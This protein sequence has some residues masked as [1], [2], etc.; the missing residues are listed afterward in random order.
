MTCH[1]TGMYSVGYYFS[2]LNVHSVLF[3]LFISIIFPY[4][5]TTPSTVHI[6]HIFIVTQSRFIQILQHLQTMP[7]NQWRWAPLFIFERP[8][9][10]AL[11]NAL[12][13]H[14]YNFDLHIANSAQSLSQASFGSEFKSSSDLEELLC[15]HLFWTCLKDLLDNGTTF[16]LIP[17]DESTRKEN[18]DYYQ[19]RGNHQFTTK[20]KEK[21]DVIITEDTECG[22]YSM[23]N[24]FWC[25][26]RQVKEGKYYSMQ[27]QLKRSNAWNM[28]INSLNWN[29]HHGAWINISCH[30]KWPL[31]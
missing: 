26:C 12:I 24:F 18:L 4:C 23:Q 16:P 28:L 7:P 30:L 11:H 14:Q 10:A 29:I 6:V 20:Y 3:V 31:H 27:R 19:N 17:I 22:F 25:S 15:N 5:V 2:V 21:L 8:D 13:L 9:R 1:T